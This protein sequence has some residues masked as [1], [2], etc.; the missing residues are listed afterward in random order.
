MKAKNS[1][2]SRSLILPGISAIF[3]AVLFLF[4][5]NKNSG[6][7]TSAKSEKAE[8]AKVLD[9]KVFSGKITT[10][11]NEKENTVNSNPGDKA[12]VIDKIRETEPSGI[13]NIQA[14]EVIVSK[15]AVTPNSRIND[16][17]FKADKR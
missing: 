11:N 7:T 3:V 12:A 8:V 9:N 17:I 16:K 14:K 2:F 15:Y 5:C 10:E 6:D 13:N 4:S 1:K